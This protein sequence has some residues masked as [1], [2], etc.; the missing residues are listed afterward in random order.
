MADF[1]PPLPARETVADKGFGKAGIALPAA[2]S[3]GVEDKFDGGGG[4]TVQ[5][6]DEFGA[7]V[8]ALCERSET[9]RFDSA[10]FVVGVGELRRVHRHRSKV[11]GHPRCLRLYRY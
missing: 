8:F 9:A 5:F 1:K 3:E 10:L 7:A 4:K 6:S 11:A 2:R